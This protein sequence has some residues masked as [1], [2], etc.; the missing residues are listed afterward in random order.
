MTGYLW[1]IQDFARRDFSA[2]K[3]N[4]VI[5]LG[6]YMRPEQDHSL[7]NLQ[8]AHIRSIVLGLYDRSVRRGDWRRLLHKALEFPMLDTI[9]VSAYGRDELRDFVIRHRAILTVGELQ[10]R[11]RLYYPTEVADMTFQN[12]HWRQVYVSDVVDEIDV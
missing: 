9:Q 3:L 6:F 7:E 5:G 11:L 12:E 4:D 2:P 8:T 10:R 1:R